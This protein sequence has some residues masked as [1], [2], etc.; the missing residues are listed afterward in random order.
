MV[1][2]CSFFFF[3]LRED[4]AGRLQASK[5]AI[6]T[7]FRSWS[8]KINALKKKSVSGLS[9]VALIDG[10]INRQTKYMYCNL[11]IY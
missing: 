3:V 7:I 11:N 9:T 5:M 6:V 2:N 1:D 4:R 10:T 8:G